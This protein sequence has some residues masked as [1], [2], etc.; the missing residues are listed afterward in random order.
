MHP[1]GTALGGGKHYPVRIRVTR[2]RSGEL[3]GVA[4]DSFVVGQV[5]EVPASLAT[6]LV[7][8][9]SAEPVSEHDRAPFHPFERR[10]DVG[11]IPPAIAADRPKRDDEPPRE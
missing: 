4:L 2:A 8:T 10:I 1:F 9:G 7:I 5:Y 6:Y 3:D 11:V